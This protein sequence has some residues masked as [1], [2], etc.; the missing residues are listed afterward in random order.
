M[1]SPFRI[2]RP[3]DTEI[4]T[5]RQSTNIT[6]TEFSVPSLELGSNTY[7]PSYGADL[8]ARS[9]KPTDF[10]PTDNTAINGK[11]RWVFAYVIDNQ[12]REVTT[13]KFSSSPGPRI[14]VTLKHP[15]D[16]NG[17]PREATT[18]SDCSG[19]ATVGGARPC[20]G[21][22][23]KQARA[24]QE[25]ALC[26]FIDISVRLGDEWIALD[27]WTALSLYRRC[28]KII[29]IRGGQ[30]TP[31]NIRLHVEREVRLLLRHGAKDKQGYWTVECIPILNYDVNLFSG[32]VPYQ[33]CDW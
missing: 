33:F 20:P 25:K 13:R 5:Y 27:A 19:M 1:S 31:A 22:G 24:L 7:K 17:K 30:P 4:D 23:K 14:R 32:L 3:T 15:E 8:I 28:K 9:L 11:S 29:S 16:Q 10:V 6:P 18:P 12:Q 21:Q 26:V 2:W